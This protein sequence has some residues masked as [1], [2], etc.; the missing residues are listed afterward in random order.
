VA[1]LFGLGS[2]SARRSTLSDASTLPQRALC[3]TFRSDGEAGPAVCVA[4]S[5][6]GLS[7]RFDGFA[8]QPLHQTFI[9]RLRWRP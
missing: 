3:R 9:R 2:Q 1:L 4:S 6:N 7:R 8:A 5:P